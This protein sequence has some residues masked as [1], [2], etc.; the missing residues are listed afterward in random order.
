MT[1]K[2]I[3]DFL[4]EKAPFDTCEEWDNVGLLVGSGYLP[5]TRV[6]VALDVTDGALEAAKAVG[7][8][9]IV[10]HHPVIFRPISRLSADSLPYR[11]AAAGISVISAHTNLDK[12]AEGVNDTLAA[13][14]GLTDIE[15]A[16]DG[17]TRMGTLPE[18]MTATAFAA[19]VAA[20]LGTPVRAA[21][22]KTVKKVALC[23]GAAG[24]SMFALMGKADCFITGEVKHHEW[25]MAAGRINVIDGGHYSTEVPVV[26]TLC[27]WLAEGFP[28][29]QVVPYHEGECFSI[30]K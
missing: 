11:L 21:G 23:G 6:L 12:A 9:L 15:I 19:H 8:D 27:R 14:L 18:E 7:A 10:T 1:V 16:A 22:D 24:S 28:T 4:G 30:V 2:E 26:D 25:L 3:L 20:V 29:L 13:R 5:A 17:M